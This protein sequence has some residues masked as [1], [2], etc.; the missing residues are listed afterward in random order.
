MSVC[1]ITL[2]A[3][4]DPKKV[5][6]LNVPHEESAQDWIDRN[7]GGAVAMGVGGVTSE[8]LTQRMSLL[9]S[10]CKYGA[11]AQTLVHPRA[12]VSDGAKIADGV[13]IMANAVVQSG[14]KLGHGVIVNTG[15]IVE[16]D[17]SIGYG[18]HVAPGA[19]VLGQCQV[20]DVCMIGAGCVILPG[21]V[22]DSGVLI[23][24]LSRHPE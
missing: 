16:H 9:T 10:L 11:L 2:S 13:T 18:S 5:T 14:A 24:A 23:P 17:T 15:A 12:C 6:W 19:I 22:I 4:A 7:R 20:G 3:Y 8:Q 1:N 21:A